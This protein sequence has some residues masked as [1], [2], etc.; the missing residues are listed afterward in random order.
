MRR[1]CL[2]IGDSVTASAATLRITLSRTPQ[3]L[4]PGQLPRLMDG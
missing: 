1:T 4:Q 3:K 2:S